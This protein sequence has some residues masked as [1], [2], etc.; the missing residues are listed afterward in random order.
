MRRLHFNARDT[1]KV[2]CWPML[3]E[4]RAR[5]LR[6]QVL[7]ASFVHDSEAVRIAVNG[8]DAREPSEAK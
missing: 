5:V 6:R 1:L 8:S 3:N 4:S 7:H 2:N